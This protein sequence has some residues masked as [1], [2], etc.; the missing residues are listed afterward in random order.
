M[1]HNAEQYHA[2]VKTFDH[3][4]LNTLIDRIPQ[5]VN[6]AG[7]SYRRL[8]TKIKEEYERNKV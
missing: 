6:R 3:D 8:V 7:K 4:R 2:K 1:I 5:N